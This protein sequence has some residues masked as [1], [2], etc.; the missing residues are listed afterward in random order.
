MQVEDD[1][2]QPQ[3]YVRVRLFID[4]LKKKTFGGNRNAQPSNGAVQ[5]KAEERQDF[6][7]F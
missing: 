1:E 6:I 3:K 2:K 5:F 7:V 4:N